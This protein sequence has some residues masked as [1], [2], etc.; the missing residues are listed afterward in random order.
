MIAEATM[1]GVAATEKP[2]A[3]LVLEDG[4]VFEG[5]AFGA[6]DKNAVGELGKLR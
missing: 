3:R 4:T 1:N 5:T 6:V 2:R